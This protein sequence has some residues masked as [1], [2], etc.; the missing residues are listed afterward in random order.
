[1]SHTVIRPCWKCVHLGVLISSAALMAVTAPASGAEKKPALLD[2]LLPADAEL[3]VD[4]YKAKA[5]GETRLFETPP[6]EL[7]KTYVYSI[8]VTWQGRT[9]LR[10]IQLRPERVTTVDLR[11][12]L[13]TS[14][15]P[16]PVGSFSLLV[17]PAMTIKASQD[18]MLP[19]RVK[20][21]DF[22]GSIRITFCPKFFQKFA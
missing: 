17:P 15:T 3:E 1:M 9:I 21:F 11:R 4:G 10:R 20:R 6:V 2:V 16:A 14:A 19:L 22:P 12:E 8:K 13:Q 5:T 7:G 18:A